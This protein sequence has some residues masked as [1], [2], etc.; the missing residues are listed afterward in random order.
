MLVLALVLAGC[1][2]PVEPASSGPLAPAGL[3]ADVGGTLAVAQAQASAVAGQT[4]QARQ[5]T[6]EQAAAYGTAEALSLA[7]RLAAQTETAQAAQA[8]A[9]ATGTALVELELTA[10][11]RA[12]QTATARLE[13][14]EATATAAEESARRATAAAYGTR[15]AREEGLTATAEAAALAREQAQAAFWSWLW[16][17][18]AM[19]AI[20]GG[21]GVGL[22]L[23]WSYGQAYIRRIQIIETRVGTIYLGA[24]NIRHQMIISPPPGVPAPEEPRLSAA[25][26]APEA[27]V[28]QHGD[29]AHLMAKEEPENIR[30]RR[31]LVL[32]LLDAAIATEGG[33]GQ[34]IPRWSRLEGWDSASSWSA[35]VRGLGEAVEPSKRGTY[36]RHGTLLELRE[37]VAQGRQEVYADA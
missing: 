6:W 35:A 22:S 7:Q 5:A 37:R 21:L 24:S 28:V 34:R 1:S 3:P 26:H 25:P 8:I 17:L 23:A 14:A 33:G 9:A 11:A 13:R 32:K 31:V 15:T 10:Q 4:A 12:A 2:A 29:N 30:A 19:A 36:L 18:S 20:A 16:P 27:V